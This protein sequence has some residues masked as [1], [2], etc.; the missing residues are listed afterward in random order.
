LSIEVIASNT[1][2]EV[3]APS[4]PTFTVVPIKGDP[5]PQG[6]QGEVGPQGPAG[7]SGTVALETHIDSATPHPVY[8]DLPSLNLLFENGLI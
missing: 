8:D 7:E 5:G 3:S 6:P 1:Q 2:I 4:I